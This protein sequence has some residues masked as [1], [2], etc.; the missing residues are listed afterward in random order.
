MIMEFGLKKVSFHSVSQLSHQSGENDHVEINVLKNVFYLTMH[1]VVES[2]P[3]NVV[4]Q[5]FQKTFF[6]TLD[7]ISKKRF[8]ER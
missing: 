8:F 5:T 7:L 6:V 3:Q 1:Q 4:D 2:V